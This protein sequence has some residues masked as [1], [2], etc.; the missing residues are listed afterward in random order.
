MRSF[1]YH[2]DHTHIHWSMTYLL[3][4]LETPKSLGSQPLKCECVRKKASSASRASDPL[5]PAFNSACDLHERERKKKRRQKVKK[6][7]RF[8]F[9]LRYTGCS[10]LETGLGSQSFISSPLL[11]LSLSLTHL[12]PPAYPPV[13][14][15]R[16]FPAVTYLSHLHPTPR[17][18][19][20]ST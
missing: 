15:L 5:N 11:S 9:L 14:S 12:F 13:P 17:H 1:A 2:H 7:T 8:G 4:R 20:L 3:V 18:P 16:S 19:P 10:S 6:Y